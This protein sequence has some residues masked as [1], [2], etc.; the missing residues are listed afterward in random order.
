MAGKFKLIVMFVAV[1]SISCLVL[2]LSGMTA[3][4]CAQDTS[5]CKTKECPLD[6]GGKCSS[7]TTCK[8]K[9][10]CNKKKSKC[11]KGGGHDLSDMMGLT[12]CAKKEL[13]KEK[14]KANL[15]EKIGPK[16]DKIADLLVNAM[17]DEYKS[18]MEGKARNAALG[19]NIRE[20]FSGQ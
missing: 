5:V 3:E 20:V 2:N 15:E 14:I 6:K 12:K 9:S 19:N 11:N 18:S 17:L 1:A 13:L 4:A 16:L 7:D 10:K 8:K